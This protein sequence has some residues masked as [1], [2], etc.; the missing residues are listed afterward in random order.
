M[1]GINYLVVLVAAIAAYAVGAIWYSPIG[2][3]KQWMKLS[4]I[5]KDDM[6]KMPLTPVQAMSLGF[7]FTLLISYVF[8]HFVVYIGVTDLPSALTLGFWAWL[9]F[10]FTTLAHSW[11]YEGKSLKLFLFNAAHLLVAFLAMAAVYGLWS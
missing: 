2:F 4:G 11:L 5:S 3:G 1:E 6:H 9:G 10:G 7:L 8:A